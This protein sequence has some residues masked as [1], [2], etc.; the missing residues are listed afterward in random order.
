MKIQRHI[1]NLLFLIVL[2]TPSITGAQTTNK[3]F[4]MV[5]GEVLKPLKLTQE[6]LLKMK[7]TEVKAKDRDDK[8]HT[9]K[10]VRL[11]DILDSAG[12]TLGKDLRGENLTK[13]VLVKAVD[14]YE[15]IFSLPEVDPEFTGQT[16]ILAYQVDGNPL[17]KGEGPF[18]IVAPND[19]RPARW[20]RELSSIKILFPKE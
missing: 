15:V 10:G 2:I 8:E 12:V 20:I 1:A 3:P 7:Q 4:F 9:F 16:I 17:P 13:Y 6:E 14:G 5:E 11:V 19:K 18:R